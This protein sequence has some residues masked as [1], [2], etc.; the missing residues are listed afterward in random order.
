MTRLPRLIVVVATVVLA[1]WN[2]GTAAAGASSAH[3]SA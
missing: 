3:A 1:V 2:L